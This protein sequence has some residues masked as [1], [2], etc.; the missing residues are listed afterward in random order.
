MFPKQLWSLL[1]ALQNS[2]PTQSGLVRYLSRTDVLDNVQHHL[3]GCRAELSEIDQA[4]IDRWL[5][6][7]RQV[8][9]RTTICK[10]FQ[11]LEERGIDLGELLVKNGTNLA[12]NLGRYGLT[13]RAAK[14]HSVVIG[15]G[16]V[17]RAACDSTSAETFDPLLGKVTRRRVDELAMVCHEGSGNHVY[18]AKLVAI[19]SPSEDRHGT[20]CL[21]ADLVNSP[22]PARE[23]DVAIDLTLAA[24]RSLRRSNRS[25]HNFV[26]DRAVNRKHQ[27]TLNKSQMIVTTRAN[28]DQVDGANQNSFNR[29]Q[30]IGTVKT[31]CRQEFRLFA[32]QK[33]LMVQHMGV[34]GDHEYL[35]MQH[36]VRV[37]RTNGKP[38]TYSDHRFR[39]TNPSCG[40]HTVSIPWNGFKTFN[41]RGKNRLE[42]VD[43][44]QYKK[45]LT[46]LQPYAPGTRDHQI[47]YGLRERTE[48]MH[49]VIDNLLPF[50]RLQRW[51]S[52]S[53]RAFLFGYL[54]GHNLFVE[55]ANA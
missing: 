4:L 43:Y 27:E 41:H 2:I 46:Y 25:P 52:R 14:S 33:A 3:E 8:P 44:D 16:T 54:I 32:V 11:S 34:G 53:K 42:P 24:R 35:E 10:M 23:A 7:G 26:Y 31:N 9:N 48:T 21:G 30:Y 17:L 6:Q 49:S 37:V 40:S 51:G 15:D 18:G 1:L 28:A 47:H 19:W 13:S 45:I 29:P 36:S 55:Q 5:E 38:Y 22:A 50:K 12:V 20:I 39:C